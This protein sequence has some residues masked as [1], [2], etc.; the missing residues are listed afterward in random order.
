MLRNFKEELIKRIKDND[1]FVIGLAF[2]AVIC[3]IGILVK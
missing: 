3:I 1:T 2:A